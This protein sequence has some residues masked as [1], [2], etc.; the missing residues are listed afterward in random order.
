MRLECPSCGAQ[1]EIPD[2]LI[3][4]TGR[5]VQC[6]DCGHTWFEAGA[7]D[8]PKPAIPTD[9]GWIKTS[10]PFDDTSADDAAPAVEDAP[11]DPVDPV[12]DTHPDT[13]PDPAPAMPPRPTV[14][15]EIADILREE[16]SIET[17]AR[18]A[19]RDTLQ[20][21]PDLGLAAPEPRRVDHTGG[22]SRKNLLPDIEAINSSLRGSETAPD[23]AT[24][25]AK[26][27]GGFSRGFL[28]V[29]MCAVL[30]AAVYVLAPH[31]MPHTPD[32]VD[33]ALTSYV[34]WVNALRLRLDLGLQS[35]LARV[36]GA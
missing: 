4:D 28:F 25:P 34:N 15:P 32:A 29:V 31:M 16:A 30:A 20:S 18:D 26:S 24:P 14:T 10:A 3:P 8:D 7:S 33:Q 35:L 11:S 13:Q 19:E 36:G 2:G 27:G 5:D 23:T 9:G 1:Y 12:P 17:A 6:S 21:Q 22:Q